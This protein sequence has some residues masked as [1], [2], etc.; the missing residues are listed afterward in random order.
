MLTAADAGH[1]LVASVRAAA[2]GNTRVVLTTAA[3]IPG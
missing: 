2:A 3:T 1:A